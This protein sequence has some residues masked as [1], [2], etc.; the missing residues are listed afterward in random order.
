MRGIYN[1]PEDENK[2]KTARNW[3]KQGFLVKD[4]AKGE[5]MHSNRNL[6][7]ATYYFREDVF[8]ACDEELAAYWQK[9]RQKK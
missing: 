9:E 7:T 3:A 5:I 6:S 8:G 2:P 1:F 4:G